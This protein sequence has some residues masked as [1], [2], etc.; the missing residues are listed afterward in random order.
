MAFRSTLKRLG[1]VILGAGLVLV[2]ALPAAAD[3]PK[4]EPYEGADERGMGIYLQ[5]GEE[6]LDG[7]DRE[8]GKQAFY[9][10]LLGLR[11]TNGSERETAKAYCVELP[12]PLEDGAPLEEVPWGEHPNPDTQFKEKAAKVNWVLQNSYPA[13]PADKAL[14]LYG[15]DEAKNSILIAATQAAVWHFSDGV[16]LRKDDSTAEDENIGDSNV[17]ELV[18][19]IYEYLTTKAEDLAEPKPTLSIEPGELT[20]EVGGKIGP[21]TIATT[22]TEAVLTADLP[23]GVTL[24]DKDGQ[25]LAVADE[26]AL[27][28]A[29]TVNVAEVWVKVDEGVEPGEVEFTVNASAKL[30]S[31]RLFVSVDK[32]KKTQSLIIATSENFPVAAKAK[33]KWVEGTVV[34]TTTEATPTTTTT[35]TTTTAPVT[36]TTAPAA[37]GGNDDLANT[38]ASIF[39]P[40]L[41]GLGL[42]G[43]GAGALLFLRRKRA[44]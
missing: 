29:A 18:Y 6:L 40:L 39:V 24:V 20:G 8:D 17:D 1:A 33:A 4:V 42:L 36:T 35:T 15:I 12:T 10:G 11:L 37:G 30:R 9:A 2:T 34:T 27:G 21:F 43:A 41:I 22:A 14:E 25:P 16:T 32:N 5:R 7:N 31:G 38:G 23:A 26:G 19:K 13:L 28:A 44:A 3:K